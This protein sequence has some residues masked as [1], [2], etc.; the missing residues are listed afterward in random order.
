M[1]A[2]KRPLACA[3]LVPQNVGIRQWAPRRVSTDEADR[4]LGRSHGVGLATSPA[5]YEILTGSL[6][7]RCRPRAL[8]E[9]SSW[10]AAGGR[11]GVIGGAPGD[12]SHSDL[13]LAPCGE[14]DRSD[15]GKQL[16]PFRGSERSFPSQRH[17]RSLRS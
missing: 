17:R 9:R 14:V 3:G 8:T 10:D 12:R 5:G 16:F 7:P 2:S 6:R 11:D 13:L 15:Q 1:K 4:E